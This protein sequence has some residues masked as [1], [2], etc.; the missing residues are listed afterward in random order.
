MERNVLARV[1]GIHD[2][3]RQL[4]RR[5]ARDRNTAIGD[6]KGPKLEPGG[7]RRCRLASKGELRLFLRLQERHNTVEPSLAPPSRLIVEPLSP[8]RPRDNAESPLPWPT[9]PED[10]RFHVSLRPRC[11]R[12]HLSRQSI[13]TEA[14]APYALR[15]LGMLLGPFPSSE[16]TEN[17]PTT[18]RPARRA[19]RARERRSAEA[20]WAL[21][22]L[23]Q[24]SQLEASFG[25]AQRARGRT[26]F[27]AGV[28]SP[29]TCQKPWKGGRPSRG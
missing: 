1:Q 9:D 29:R 4:G 14:V 11:L 21:S 22:T 19:G 26:A 13:A 2:L 10:L 25:A 5:L 17:L 16:T 20:G 6:R 18:Q 24:A 3:A 27:A 12:Q 15:T 8:A 23:A 7:G 28:N